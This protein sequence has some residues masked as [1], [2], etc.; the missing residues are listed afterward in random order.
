MV[1]L[2]VTAWPTP[3]RAVILIVNRL[4]ISHRMGL[5]VR[6][7]VP[8]PLDRNVNPRGRRRTSR[9]VGSGYPLPR[10]TNRVRR[11]YRNLARPGETMDGACRTVSVNA[12]VAAGVTPL[13]AS[14]VSR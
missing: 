6:L 12:C 5:A 2:W 1:S 10:T 8:L 3:L 9:S 7:A 11:P 13:L 14:R 4:P